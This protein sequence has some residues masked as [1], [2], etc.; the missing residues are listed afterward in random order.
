[1]GYYCYPVV[2]NEG[3]DG[4]F[5]AS[6]PSIA[7]CHTQ[8]DTIPVAM[9]NIR[10]AIALCIEVMRDRGEPLPVPGTTVLSEVVVAA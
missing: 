10:E 1:M 3:E 9:E 4:K 7:G 5:I 8:G 6:C 2:I